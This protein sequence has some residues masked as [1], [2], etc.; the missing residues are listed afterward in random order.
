MLRHIWFKTV[1]APLGIKISCMVLTSWGV[2]GGCRC[3]HLTHISAGSVRI[4][5]LSSWR[6]FLSSTGSW[7]AKR[8]LAVVI[9]GYEGY[10]H[11]ELHCNDFGL[12]LERWVGGWVGGGGGLSW[13]MTVAKSL[14][15]SNLC[16]ESLKEKLDPFMFWIREP[17]IF[18]LMAQGSSWEKSLTKWTNYKPQLSSSHL[19][20]SV[21]AAA[22]YV[23]IPYD[24]LFLHSSA[25]IYSLWP[26]RLSTMLLFLSHHLLDQQRCF[27]HVSLVYL[28]NVITTGMLKSF[29]AA[30]LYEET[31]PCKAC[32][33][34]TL[35]DSKSYARL[36]ALKSKS[37]CEC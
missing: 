31:K 19:C 17:K 5:A 14:F 11:C 16:W 15:G 34:K 37:V 3:H 26:Q 21:F 27:R 12:S 6:A 24:V 10:A 33:V 20:R 32:A 9:K 8:S 1:W 22:H 18:F 36:K 35:A 29:M 4:P 13:T 2:G 7:Q 30:F 28:K 25:T 23:L